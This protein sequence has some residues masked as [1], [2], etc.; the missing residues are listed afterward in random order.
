MIALQNLLYRASI[1]HSISLYCFRKGLLFEA[2]VA[3]EDEA[4]RAKYLQEL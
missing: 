1:L 3:L 4:N 2:V